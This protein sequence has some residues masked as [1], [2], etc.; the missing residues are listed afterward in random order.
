MQRLVS[1]CG[2]LDGLIVQVDVTTPHGRALATHHGVRG[3]PTYVLVDADGIER[4]RLLGE[5]SRE[6][7]AAAVERAF[8]VSCWG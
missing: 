7:I 3:T 4:A 2:E 8:G 1:A 6:D 5:N